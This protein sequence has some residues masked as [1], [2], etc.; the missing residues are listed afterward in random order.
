M[1]V[2]KAAVAGT[3]LGTSENK[4]GDVNLC[5]GV[6]A[7]D[8]GDGGKRTDSGTGGWKETGSERGEKKREVAGLAFFIRY[9]AEEFLKVSHREGSRPPRTLRTWS[10]PTGETL[11]I[12]SDGAFDP[13]TKKGGWGFIIRDAAGDV[14]HAGAGAVQYAMDAL[15]VEVL[16][17]LAAVRAAGDRGSGFHASE[18]GGRGKRLLLG[19]N[20]WSCP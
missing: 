6:A 20:W 3:E 9:Q 8:L 19:A 16:A 11:K 17:C 14:V 12:N 15:H 5:L 2:R 13:V 18:A 10:K 7:G 1:Q 4:I